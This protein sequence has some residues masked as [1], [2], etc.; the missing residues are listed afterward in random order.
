MIADSGSLK[1]F[2]I[3]AFLWLPPCF[4]VCYLTA[5]THPAIAGWFARVIVNIVTPG[6]VVALERSGSELAFVTTIKIYPALGQA[7]L[8][9]PEVNALI[10]TYGLAVFL[11]LMLAERAKLRKIAIGAVIHLLFQCWG[12]A[13]DFLVQVGVRLGPELV[14]QANLRGWR[15]EAIALGYQ[16]GVLIFPP[17]VPVILWAY[18]GTFFR[19]RLQR[20]ST[21]STDH[22]A[23]GCRK[24]WP[25]SGV[26]SRK[27]R[28]E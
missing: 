17:L 5:P 13:F 16:L 14:T 2:F 9:L 28:F 19:N 3:R 18:L 6:V 12:I 21:R 20:D 24:N 23:N 11:A 8:L 26:M 27:H 25:Q 22:I 4:F 1:A 7:A 10:Y 15:V